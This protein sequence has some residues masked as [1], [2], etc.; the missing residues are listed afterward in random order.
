VAK[1]CQQV[2]GVDYSAPLIEI[3]R[4]NFGAPNARYCC[5]SAMDITSKNLELTAP[6]TKIYMYEA[7]QH[8]TEEQLAPLIERLLALSSESAVI[9]FASITHQRKLS[10][11]YN[12]PELQQTYRKN[13]QRGALGLGTWWKKSV[14]RQTCSL[15]NLRC[16]FLSQPEELHTA[17][18]RFDVRITRM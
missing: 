4:E 16:E 9:L 8:F 18:Y 6:V 15:Y 10:K 11:F 12:T 1:K 2:V 13:R 14:I 3:A 17:H 7:L 5:L